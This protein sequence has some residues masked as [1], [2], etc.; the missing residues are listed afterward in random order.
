MV[1]PSLHYPT[2][3]TNRLVLLVGLAIV[4]GLAVAWLLIQIE[5]RVKA[6]RV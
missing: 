5:A 1:A 4:A 2:W 6:Q 3:K